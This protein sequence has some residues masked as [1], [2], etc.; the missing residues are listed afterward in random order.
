MN[1]VLIIEDDDT[2]RAILKRVLI[3][4]FD[5]RPI[6]ATNGKEGLQILK[7]DIPDI[8]LLDNTMP[9]M[10]GITF[11][12]NLRKEEKYNDIQVLVIT[13]SDDSDIVEQMIQMGISDYVLKPIDPVLTFKRIQNAIDRINKKKNNLQG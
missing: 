4:K 2:V 5:I 12:K 13:A 9:V 3:N 1:K 11:L 10:D 7:N 8:I 6:E